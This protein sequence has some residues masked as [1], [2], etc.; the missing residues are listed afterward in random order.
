MVCRVSHT[1]TCLQPGCADSLIL[2]EDSIGKLTLALPLVRE[3]KSSVKVSPRPATKDSIG[4]TPSELKEDIW[5]FL[6]H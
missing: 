5:L 3:A 6:L 2:A 4:Q 1:C